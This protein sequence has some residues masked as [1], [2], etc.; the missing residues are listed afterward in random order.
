MDR[1]LPIT[2]RKSLLARLLGR[3]ISRI[4]GREYSLDPNIPVSVLLS[5]A[6]WRLTWLVRGNLKSLMLRQGLCSVFVAPGVTW[7]NAGPSDSAA[8]SPLNGV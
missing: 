6:M 4:K 8:E 3:V 1:P 5:T 2:K 7:R